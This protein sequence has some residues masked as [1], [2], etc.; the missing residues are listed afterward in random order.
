MHKFSINLGDSFLL[1]TPPTGMHLYFAIAQISEDLY[2]FVNATSPRHKS[3]TVCILQPGSDVPPF[4]EHESV[5]AYNYAR[6]ISCDEISKI[7]FGKPHLVKGSCS[8]TVLR[9]IQLGGVSS[10]RLK[11]K[12]KTVLK[13]LLGIP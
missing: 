9:D 7:I 8:A 12:Y 10:K 11:N 1:E 2:L 3:E 6:E 13:N 4:I 5:I